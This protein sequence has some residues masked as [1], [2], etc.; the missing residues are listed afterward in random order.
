[1]LLSI[2]IAAQLVE[3]RQLTDNRA[4][5]VSQAIEAY[6][7]REGHYPDELS[8]LT[9]RYLLSVRHPVVIYPQEWCFESGADYY[10]LGYVNR[11]HWSDPRLYAN[12]TAIS[13]AVPQDV[14]LCKT[15]ISALK[16]R[17]PIFS[18]PYAWQVS[19]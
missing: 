7:A 16:E 2:Y 5:R 9:P 11:D 8:Q 15:E 13:G 4:D 10:A 19:Q 3:F 1:M 17:Y 6:Y 18:Y 14:D 12:I